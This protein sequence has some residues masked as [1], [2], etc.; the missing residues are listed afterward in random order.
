MVQ[1][2]D[3]NLW[4]HASADRIETIDP[5]GLGRATRLYAEVLDAIDR[6]STAT[7]GLEPRR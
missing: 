7:L 6:E 4:F 3:T 1:I 5:A 2:I